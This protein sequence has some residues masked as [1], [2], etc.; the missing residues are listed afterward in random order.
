MGKTNT[1]LKIILA[2]RELTQRDL[3]FATGLSEATVSTTIKHGVATWETSKVIAEWLGVE[4]SEIFNGRNYG[5]LK[6]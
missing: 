4:E 1:K 3:A 6:D 5:E 2:Q